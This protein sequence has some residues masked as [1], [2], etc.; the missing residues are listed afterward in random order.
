MELHEEPV[1]G[2]AFG[3]ALQAHMRQSPYDRHYV[4]RSDGLIDDMPHA[5]Y[6]AEP[7]DWPEVD[8][9]CLE[10][11][12]GS[13]LDVGAGAG[14]ATLAAAD[15]GHRVTALDVSAGAIEVCRQRGIDDLF[16][17]TVQE[18]AG[19]SNGASYDTFLM[20]GNNIGLLGGPAQAPGL[21]AA[22]AAVARPGA[23]I[24]GT[25]GHIYKT[26]NPD[27]LAYH[28]RNRALGRMPGELRLRTRFQRLAGE[29]FDYLFASPEELA[30]IAETGGWRLA[31]VVEGSGYVYLA[32]LR[33]D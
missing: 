10:R 24:V 25:A 5:V 32:E 3:A 17:G 14:R 19:G 16:H 6:F 8:R 33:L 30:R 11:L 28:E 12:S 23:R 15:L 29:W 22:L 1:L 7:P 27:H 31:D 9:G 21:L 13:V 20:L 18:L 26:D 4:E 2:D